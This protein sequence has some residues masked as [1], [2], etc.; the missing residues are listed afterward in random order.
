[1]NDATLRKMM[2][3]K[4]CKGNKLGVFL[5]RLM[6]QERPH[7]KPRRV[8]VS[9]GTRGEYEALLVARA[10]IGFIRSWGFTLT[11]KGADLASGRKGAHRQPKLDE[12]RWLATDMP[13]FFAPRS[14]IDPPADKPV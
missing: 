2:R 12:A 7:L 5:L 1:M 6:V 4:P 8:E 13:L 10:V 9:L 3:R 11:N 14:N